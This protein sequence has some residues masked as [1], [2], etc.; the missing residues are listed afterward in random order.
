[1]TTSTEQIAEAILEKEERLKE[2][3]EGYGSVV[4]AYSG[5]VD[6]TYLADVA[7]DVLG[8]KAHTILADSPSIPRS[9][10]EEAS[11]FARS[12]GWVFSIIATNEFE[13]DDFLK[14]DGRRCYHCRT[15]LFGKMR[16]YAEAHGV[17]TLAYGAMADDLLDPTRV[18]SLAAGELG[19]VSPLQEAGL[20]KDAIRE[21]SARRGLP[22]ASKASFACLASRLPV[23]TPVSAKVLSKVEQAEEVLKR[24][25]FHQY[26]VRHHDDM[27]RIEIAPEDFERVMRPD[28]R[29]AIV[30]EVSAVG[31]RFV[32]LDL[33]GYRTGSTAQ[34]ASGDA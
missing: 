14:N 18:G 20:G 6:S 16:G 1:M 12:R 9:E 10:L 25:G 29:E 7:H 32:T 11:A 21:L 13:N 22:T 3:L 34:S 26:R 33:A 8:D 31:Y 27:A 5:G 30:K 15:E 19:V 28:V 2:L 24:L 17:K 23:G 4:V